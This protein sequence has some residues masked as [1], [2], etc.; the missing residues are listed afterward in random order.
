M[1][2]KTQ[3]CTLLENVEPGIGGTVQF[4]PVLKPLCTFSVN[5]ISFFLP[6]RNWK[7]FVCMLLDE[8]I[9]S[10]K[11]L[12]QGVKQSPPWSCAC[13]KGALSSEAACV[14]CILDRLH[15]WSCC[16]HQTSFS[17]MLMV[18]KCPQTVSSPGTV[19]LNRLAHKLEFSRERSLK[20][21]ECFC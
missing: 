14:L 8:T 16:I 4:R 20:L 11:L 5:Y 13:C 21:I 10:D 19:A 2:M 17:Q 15:K 7:W 12:M 18:I 3:C 6:L 9:K 1:M